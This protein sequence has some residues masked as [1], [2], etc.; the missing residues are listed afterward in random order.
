ME[1][2]FFLN[3]KNTKT[4]LGILWLAGWLAGCLLISCLAGWL[5]GR[6]VGRLV[7]WLAG[8]LVWVGILGLGNQALD[9]G[10]TV[11]RYP[12]EPSAP[13]TYNPS[14]FSLNLKHGFN[15]EP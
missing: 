15:K 10:G 1:T 12:G 4:E 6:L 3:K 7:G 2:F 14:A 13:L 5:A 8:W 11:W 9:A